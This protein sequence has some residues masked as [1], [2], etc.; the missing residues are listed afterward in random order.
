[1]LSEAMLCTLRLG[2]E[3]RERYVANTLAVGG[4]AVLDAWDSEW[5]QK[6]DLKKLARNENGVGILEQIFGSHAEGVQKL[7]L[8]EYMQE[9]LGFICP[10]NTH[11]SMLIRA[12]TYEV[13]RRMQK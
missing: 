1:M 6:I 8:S 10:N 2:H 11:T 4:A 7:N 9:A 5:Y 3:A 13:Q 12:W